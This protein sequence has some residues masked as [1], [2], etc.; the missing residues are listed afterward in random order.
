MEQVRATEGTL[1]TLNFKEK[2]MDFFAIYIADNYCQNTG[3]IWKKRVMY[4]FYHGSMVRDR[5]EIL[6]TIGFR[7]QLQC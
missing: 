5:P 6:Q 3:G 4:Q 1:N 2:L 7:S